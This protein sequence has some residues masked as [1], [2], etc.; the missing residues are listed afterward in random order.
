MVSKK[1][2]LFLPRINNANEIIMKKTVTI[3]PFKR[4][5]FSLFLLGVVSFSFFS[6]SEGSQKDNLK[7]VKAEDIKVVGEKKAELTSPPHVPPSTANREATRLEVDLEIL[8]EVGEMT[9]GVEYT[10][11]TF[12]GTVPGSFIRAK[13]GDEIEFHLKNHPENKLPHNIDLH[14]V[15]GPGGGAVSSFVAPGHQITFSFKALHPGLY[16]Y[17][18]AT[19]PVGMHIANGMY[20]LILVEPTEGLP[21]V[22]HEYYVM[23]GDFYTT[24]DYGEAGLQHFDM[25]KALDEDP[26]YVVFNGKV[27]ALSGENALKAKVG[28]TVRLY[29]GNGGPNLVSSFHV[30]GEIFDRV[31]IGGGTLENNNVQTELIPAGGAAIVE[32]KVDAPGEY[33]LVDH[34]IM[35]AFNKGALAVLD[36]EGDKNMKVF[37]GKTQEGIYLPEGSK[38][39]SMPREDE[40]EEKAKTGGLSKDE[41]MA[42][43]KKVYEATCFACHQSDGGGV[44]HAFPPLAEADYLNDDV[45]RAI[46]VVL[47]GKRGPITV[48][49][50]DYDGVMPAQNLSDEEAAAILT[51][52]YNSWGNNGTVVTEGMVRKVRK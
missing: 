49:G 30:I 11:W 34:S 26:D 51:Y 21:E 42:L 50:E 27:G 13:A 3:T 29:V 32:F 15:N 6:C 39:Q 1:A 23:Q 16:V 25:Q 9:N 24:G 36:V 17:H 38:I 45:N 2:L 7:K 43:G 14:A 41:Q 28:E 44:P 4:G 12:G 40:G 46:D 35:R 10:Y 18:C 19:A 33:L 20:G 5:L 37:K 31:H 47:H 48:N 8:E 22:D 52:V